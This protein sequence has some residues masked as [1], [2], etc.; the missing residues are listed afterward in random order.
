[1]LGPEEH[2]AVSRVLDSPQLV[3][4]PEAESFELAF[5]QAIGGGVGATTVSSATAG[6]YLAYAVLGVGPG[7]DVVVPA[8]T[9]VATAHAAY[10]LGATVRFADVDTSSGNVTAE[11]LARAITPSTK[12]ICVVHYLGLPVD[13]QEIL[14][15]AR[16]RGIPVVEDCALALGTRYEGSH[17]GTMGDI[18][19]F[20]FYPAKHMT[21]GEGGMVVSTRQDL[22]AR[23]KSM[24]AFGYDKSLTERT[25][26]GVYDIKD[27]GLNLRMG[28]IAAAIGTVQLGRLPHFAERRRTNSER[29]RAN[30]SRIDGVVLQRSPRPGEDHAHYCE[31]ARF[32]EMDRDSRDRL[33]L[34]M[35]ARGIGTSVYYPVTLPQSRFYSTR[36]NAQQD[37]FPGASQ[38]SHHSIA[39]PVGPHLEP[40]DMDVI[41]EGLLESLAEVRDGN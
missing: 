25:V 22:I 7:S 33:A 38:Y 4:G 40:A 1:M 6:L 10:A 20:S 30:L 31:V 12:A 37:A 26:P 3:H 11:L 21:T 16:D 18:G 34:A 32:P 19:V 9:H 17:A 5:A 24:K 27:F 2:A 36:P 13:M 28:E 35:Q 15:L 8:L 39:L 41:S 14:N 29:L 23:V